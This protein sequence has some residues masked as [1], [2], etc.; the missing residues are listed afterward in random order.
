MPICSLVHWC[1]R[2]RQPDLQGPSK[3]E[4]QDVQKLLMAYGASGFR[5]LTQY[6][7]HAK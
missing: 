3:R 4:V 1:S 5:A 7:G 2:A 6:M